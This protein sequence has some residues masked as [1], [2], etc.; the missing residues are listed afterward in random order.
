MAQIGD[1]ETAMEALK[2]EIAPDIPGD[3][4]VILTGFQ[5]E[6]LPLLEDRLEGQA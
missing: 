1:M 4:N 5:T 3:I 2:G 6:L